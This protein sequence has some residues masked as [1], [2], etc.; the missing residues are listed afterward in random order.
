MEVQQTQVQTDRVLT[1]PN[2]LSALRIL[3]VPLFVWLVLVP[4][5]DGWAVAVLALSGFTDWL[6]GTLARAWHQISRVGQVLDPVADRLFIVVTVL[7]LAVREIVPWWLVIVL[8]GRDLFVFGVQLVERSRSRPIIPVNLVGKAATLCLLYA[9]PLLLL[10]D[11]A[12]SFA[13]LLEPVAW[14]FALWGVGLYLWSAALYAAQARAVA[15][16]RTLTVRV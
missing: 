12:G 10:T 5:A 3:L 2:G 1:L 14:A 6:D 16:G 9:F 8:L 13:Q 7:V 4:E 15:S 11:T